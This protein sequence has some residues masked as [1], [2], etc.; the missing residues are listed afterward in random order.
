M[1]RKA[2]DPLF[3]ICASNPS[4]RIELITVRR[5]T[6]SRKECRGARTTKKLSPNIIPSPP[7]VPEGVIVDLS[8]LPS[9]VHSIV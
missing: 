5:G 4:I 6:P 1:F 7:T 8:S 3:I 2:L 9:L